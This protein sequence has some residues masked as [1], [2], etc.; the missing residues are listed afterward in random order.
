MRRFFVLL[1]ALAVAGCYSPARSS[2][3]YSVNSEGATSAGVRAAAD[4]IPGETG[5]QEIIGIALPFGP[6]VAKGALLW[7]GTTW[8]PT[9]PMSAQAAP[10]ALPSAAPQGCSTQRTVMVPETYYETETR[11]VPKTRMVPRT[12]NVPSVPVPVPQ[13]APSGCPEPPISQAQPTCRDGCCEF[14]RK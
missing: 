11:Q 14:A 12:I 8:S 6:F 9:I 5:P 2:R 3:T 7:D 13:A 4:A 1:L 10:C